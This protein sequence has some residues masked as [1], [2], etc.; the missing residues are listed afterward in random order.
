M[1]NFYL[2]IVKKKSPYVVIRAQL[3]KKKI[4]LNAMKFTFI[5][6]IIVRSKESNSGFNTSFSQKQIKQQHK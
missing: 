2:K 6:Q 3:N 5:S 4:V 1:R